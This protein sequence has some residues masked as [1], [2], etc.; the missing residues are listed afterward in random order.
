MQ[1]AVQLYQQEASRV[2][3]DQLILEHLSLVRHA[4]GR[5]AARL[6]AGVDV[7]NVESAGVLGLVEAANRFDPER[8]ILFATYA[9][10]RIRGAMLDE[11]RRNSFLPQ[12]I[13]EKI[14]G[15]RGAYA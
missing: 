12:Q 5:L 6:P 7:E 13:L 4:M 8:G 15:I 10:T 1:P 11:L 14:S 2:R 9:Y 3:R